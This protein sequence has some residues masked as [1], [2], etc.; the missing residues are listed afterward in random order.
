M[1][2]KPE[3][4]LI[5]WLTLRDPQHLKRGM[6]WRVARNSLISSSDRKGSISPNVAPQIIILREYQVIHFRMEEQELL[7]SNVTQGQ[8]EEIMEIMQPASF[9]Q[10]NILSDRKRKEFS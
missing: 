10:R 9:K 1:K 5:L 7:I 3:K 6:C 2:K 8:L 4:H